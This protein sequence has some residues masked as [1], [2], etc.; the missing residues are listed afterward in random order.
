V[1]PFFQGVIVGLQISSWQH[2]S[3]VWL[4]HGRGTVVSG[5]PVH[6]ERLTGEQTHVQ[7]VYCTAGSLPFSC[8][9]EAYKSRL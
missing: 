5:L 9:K 6:G 3:A 2:H 7:G 1:V 4:L 8:R